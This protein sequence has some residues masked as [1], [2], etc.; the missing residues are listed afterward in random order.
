MILNRRK[1]EVFSIDDTRLIPKN[2][3]GVYVILS[4]SENNKKNIHY[5]G[6]TVDLKVRLSG[7]KSLFSALN[8]NGFNC[9]NVAFLGIDNWSDKAKTERA[10]VSK[11]KPAY[12]IH[13]K[14]TRTIPPYEMKLFRLEI[15]K[16]KSAK[17]SDYNKG[18]LDC[19]NWILFD[20]KKPKVLN[21]K[22]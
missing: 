12:N 11:Y 10:F 4:F 5:V 21:T 1:F 19:L 7:H 3:S 16:N 22:F 6:R 18:I 17:S 2:K 8:K 14:K 13:L 20:K 15:L 9:I